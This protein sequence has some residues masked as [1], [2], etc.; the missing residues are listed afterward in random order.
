MAACWSAEDGSE[1]TGLSLPRR[2]SVRLRSP[3]LATDPHW[4]SGSERQ[5]LPTRAR[6]VAWGDESS[7]ALL[8]EA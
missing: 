5:D 4:W 2:R 7:I 8:V 3:Y 1:R 6:V